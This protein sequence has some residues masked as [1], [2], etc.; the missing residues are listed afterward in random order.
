MIMVISANVS[1]IKNYDYMRET[2]SGWDLAALKKNKH[3]VPPIHISILLNIL[4]EV[5]TFIFFLFN[6]NSPI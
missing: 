5:K 2:H 3:L 4:C 1:N 6:I